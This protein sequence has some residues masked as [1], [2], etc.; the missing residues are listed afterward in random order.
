MFI[1][2]TKECLS[3]KI[4]NGYKGDSVRVGYLLNF[5]DEYEMLNR[6]VNFSF[7]FK[8]LFDS[9]DRFVIN[10]ENAEVIIKNKNVYSVQNIYISIK[11][12]LL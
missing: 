9:K 2:Y 5:N 1:N 7:R 4:E 6:T 12:I 11:Y 3:Y 10:L 8:Q